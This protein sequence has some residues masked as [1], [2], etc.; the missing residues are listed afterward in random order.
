[1]PTGSLR[2]CC[3]NEPG[4]GTVHVLIPSQTSLEWPQWTVSF[5]AS[6]TNASPLSTHR[7]AI[8][9][10]MLTVSNLWTDWRNQNEIYLGGS[11]YEWC[12]PGCTRT[13]FIRLKKIIN[14]KPFVTIRSYMAPPHTTHFFPNTKH[15]NTVSVTLEVYGGKKMDTLVKIIGTDYYVSKCVWGF[16]IPSI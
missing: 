10:L 2:F 16:C 11:K 8:K 5:S 12:V 15:G 6:W 13:R 7:S 14:P 1:M 3:R 9:G 4:D